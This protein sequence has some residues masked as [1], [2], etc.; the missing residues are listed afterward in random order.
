M[1]D[2]RCPFGKFFLEGG[3]LSIKDYFSFME[4]VFMIFAFTR[5]EDQLFLFLLF[6]LATLSRSNWYLFFKHFIGFLFMVHLHQLILLYSSIHFIFSL[7]SFMNSIDNYSSLGVFIQLDKIIFLL[8]L[9][10][11]LFLT[12]EPVT[13]ISFVESWIAITWIARSVLLRFSLVG[14]THA[15][16]AILF[17]SILTLLELY[18]SLDEHL[19]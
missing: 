4:V 8:F 11:L 14:L 7:L 15:L 17:P 5:M 18:R 10:A 6:G 19:G 2:V 9:I 16:L 1:I 12:A 13:F 3:L